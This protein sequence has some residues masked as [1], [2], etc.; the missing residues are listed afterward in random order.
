MLSRRMPFPRVQCQIW[1]PHDGGRDAYGNE[2][3]TW[4]EEPDVVTECSYAPGYRY[5]DTDDDV[6]DWRPHG[7]VETM[8]FFMPK[9][10]DAGL[11]GALVRALPPDDRHVAARR[12]M[13]VGD[14][15]SYMRDATP[16]DMSW[17]VRAVRFDG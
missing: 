17:A 5:A 11:R 1:L 12:Y 13:V 2:V 8:T 16:G 9:S 3:V 7:D 10:L 15:H 14:P 4:S 6:E